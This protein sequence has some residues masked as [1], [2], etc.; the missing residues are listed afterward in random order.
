MTYTRVRSEVNPLGLEHGYHPD[1][2]DISAAY[3]PIHGDCMCLC[4]ECPTEGGQAHCD[5][6]IRR[7][8]VDC[9]MLNDERCVL[10]RP[11]DYQQRWWEAELKREHQRNEL[12]AMRDSL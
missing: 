2:S 8:G 11:L 1:C 5:W 12:K 6:G 9:A 10:H 7:L 3:C 4:E